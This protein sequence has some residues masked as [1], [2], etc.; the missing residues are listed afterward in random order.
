[1]TQIVWIRHAEKQ[2]ANNKGPKGFRQHDSPIKND[3]FEMERIKYITLNLINNYGIPD[4]II[5]SPF[6]RTRQTM[7]KM[8]AIIR[9]L[10]DKDISFQCDINIGEY[11]GFQ[12]PKGELADVEATTSVYYPN[13]KI[14]L[15]ESIEE[16]KTRVY[17]HLLNIKE[18]KGTVWVI[19]HGFVIKNIAETLN[20]MFDKSFENIFE[21]GTLGSLKYKFKTS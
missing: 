10:S 9:T 19:S 12:K 6:L 8:Y 7:E 18:K 1:M 20:D 21:V 13:N 16:L 2:Y 3:T 17:N 5:Y 11:L 14:Y 15:G 4:T